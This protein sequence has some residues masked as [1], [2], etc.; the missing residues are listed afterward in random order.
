MIAVPSLFLEHEENFRF[1]QNNNNYLLYTAHDVMNNSFPP[2]SCYQFTGYYVFRF[3]DDY[4]IPGFHM[5]KLF[6]RNKN[7]QLYVKNELI[8]LMV[9][10][11]H[12]N[13]I[14]LKQDAR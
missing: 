11:P 10:R 7:K 3:H 2:P 6:S 12:T 9:L 5:E 4:V 8:F 14:L 1:K 13:K